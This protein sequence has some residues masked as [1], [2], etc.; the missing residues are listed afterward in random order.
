MKGTF[1][2][3]LIVLFL[4]IGLGGGSFFLFGYK[5]N[6]SEGN[7]TG[8]VMKFSKRGYVFKTY[9]GQLDLTNITKNNSGM[10]S[11]TWDFSVHGND[12]ATI[13]AID[14]A[15]TENKPIKLHYEEKFF[16]FSWRGD[17]K[18]FVVKVEEIT[19]SPE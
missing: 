3:V 9:E 19:Q 15:M 14:K 10:I 6:Y 13:A 11:G 1:I 17:T 7:R 12:E 8:R 5:A 16:Q 4:L 18:Y 2:K